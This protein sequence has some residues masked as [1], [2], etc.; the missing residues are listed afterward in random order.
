MSLTKNKLNTAEAASVIVKVTVVPDPASSDT[1]ILLI[2]ALESD[3]AVYIV[4]LSV[5]D[6]STFAFLY[7]LAT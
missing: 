2:I 1:I 5:V 6:K 7:I 3:G 4:V